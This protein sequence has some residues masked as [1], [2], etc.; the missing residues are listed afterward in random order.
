[1]VLTAAGEAVAARIA[2]RHELL[3]HFLRLLGLSDEVITRDVEGLEHH[4]SAET[5]QALERVSR[6]LEQHPDVV[7][8]LR[9]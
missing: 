9:E 2:H 7:A 3:T 8:R 5:F 1:M 4:I 6:Y